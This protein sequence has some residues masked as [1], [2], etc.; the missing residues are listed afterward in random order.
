[1]KIEIELKPTHFKESKILTCLFH[2]NMTEHLE[3]GDSKF[4]YLFSNKITSKI[5]KMYF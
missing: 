3:E 5:I 2:W 4:Y 1:M